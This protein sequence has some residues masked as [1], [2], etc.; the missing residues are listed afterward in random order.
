MTD[1]QQLLVEIFKEENTHARHTETQRLEV[2]KFILVAGA[3]LFGA[4]ATLQFDRA[5]C[6]P[7]AYAL[8]FLGFTALMLTIVYGMR[9]DDHRTRARAMRDALATSILSKESKDI[10]PPIDKSLS[11]RAFWLALDVAIILFGVIYVSQ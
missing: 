3:A 9:F 1:E 10:L 7:L 5:K 4:M 8:I 2:T 6:R 11:V